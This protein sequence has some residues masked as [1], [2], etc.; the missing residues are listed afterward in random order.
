[1]YQFDAMRLFC[2]NLRRLIISVVWLSLVA[3]CCYWIMTGAEAWAGGKSA[4]LLDLHLTPTDTAVAAARLRKE[5][6]K[7]HVVKVKRYRRVMQKLPKERNPEL[8]EDRLV[9]VG[10]DATGRELSRAIVLDPRLVR[11]E[12]GDSSG[13]LSRKLLYKDDVE[14]SVALPDDPAIVSVIVYHPRWTGKHFV[15]DAIGQTK[16]TAPHNQ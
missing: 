10:L 2:T 13:K 12:F 1:M 15:L 9:V 6:P 5:A 16:L 14:L 8:A 11:A 4:R 7:A 3:G